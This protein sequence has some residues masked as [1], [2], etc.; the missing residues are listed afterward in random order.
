MP[1]LIAFTG[2]QAALTLNAK[3]IPAHQSLAV[4]AGDRLEVGPILSG[5]RLYLALQGEIEATPWLGSPSTY[6]PAKLGGQ[7]YQDGDHLASKG[8]PRALDLETP[9][10]L[11]PFMGHS[12]TL[13]AICGAEFEDLP[14]AEQN[15][16]FSHVFNVSARA[17]RMGVGLIGP[18]IEFAQTGQ[19]ASVP[20]FPGTLQWPPKGEA[21][22]LLSDAQTSGGY[23]RLVQTIRADRHLLGQLRPF[24]RLQFQRVTP[25][26]ARRVLK[27]KTKL[28]QDWLGD[29]FHLF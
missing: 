20:V 25:D 2:G 26:Q 1:G 18:A 5:C 13:R 22:L 24:D 8:E 3:I 16:F 6:L 11:R 23:P 19:M 21:F 17:S 29:D 10:P 28:L 12:W 9:H 7:L 27:A 4:K 14:E 15:R